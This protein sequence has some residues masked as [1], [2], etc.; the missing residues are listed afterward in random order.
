VTEKEGLAIIFA[1]KKFR[2]YSAA[3]Y[4]VVKLFTDHKSLL[5]YFKTSIPSSD[6]HLR[7]ISLFNEMKVEL[8]Y[9]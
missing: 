8:L 3:S 6:S 9:E 4:F 7:W 5:V 2:P 1:L